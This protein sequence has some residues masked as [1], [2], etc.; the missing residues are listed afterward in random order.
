[1]SKEQEF[2][3]GAFFDAHWKN[4][5]VIAEFLTRYGSPTT[6]A[7]VIKWRDRKSVPGDKLVMLL[8]FLE[9]EHG[10][11]ISLIPYMKG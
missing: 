7:A 5:R 11:P 1:M 4:P 3:V 8:L 2:N 9:M 6:T 10:A